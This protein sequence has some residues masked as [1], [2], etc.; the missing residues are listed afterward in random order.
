MIGVS[1]NDKYPV[2]II[3]DNFG[4]LFVVD[5]VT[6]EIVILYGTVLWYGTW[7]LVPAGTGIM[8][9]YGIMVPAAP[10]AGG[11]TTGTAGTSTGGSSTLPSGTVLHSYYSRYYTTIVVQQVRTSTSRMEVL[12]PG[13]N[14]QQVLVPYIHSF[15]T[16]CMNTVRARNGSQ[17]L[18][19]NVICY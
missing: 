5:Y 9:P 16:N 3:V 12:V 13:T 10:A 1:T 15:L 11:G 2:L 8:A 19:K 4:Q 17:I 6:I 14:N 18:R 7:Y